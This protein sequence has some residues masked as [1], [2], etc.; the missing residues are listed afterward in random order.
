MGNPPQQQSAGKLNSCAFFICAIV[1]PF[2]LS[3]VPALIAVLCHIHYFMFW[4]SNPCI[5]ETQ[6]EFRAVQKQSAWKRQGEIDGHN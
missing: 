6:T 4:H 2:S 3:F 1:I 5:P